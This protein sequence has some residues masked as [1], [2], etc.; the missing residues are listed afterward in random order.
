MSLS[1]VPG[2]IYGIQSC[3]GT[4]IISSGCIGTIRD[5]PYIFADV[6]ELFG[7]TLKPMTYVMDKSTIRTPR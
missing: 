3:S 7:L 1:K 2:W 6:A 4:P 5:N